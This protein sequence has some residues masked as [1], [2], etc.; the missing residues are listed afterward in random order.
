MECTVGG[1][2]PER[3][4]ATSIFPEILK[5]GFGVHLALYSMSTGVLSQGWGGRIFMLTSHLHLATRLKDNECIILLPLYAFTAWSGRTLLT[6]FHQYLTPKWIWYFLRLR[7]ET[8]YPEEWLKASTITVYFIVAGGGK[9]LLSTVFSFNHITFLK[10][11]QT[12]LQLLRY[13]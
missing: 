4:Q 8:N 3:V 13:A 10:Q 12:S 9:Y 2:N 7:K 5:T 11:T 1:S 6:N